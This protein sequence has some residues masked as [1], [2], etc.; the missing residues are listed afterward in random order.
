MWLQ[1]AEPQTFDPLHPNPTYLLKSYKFVLV[2]GV[3]ATL[4]SAATDYKSSNQGFYFCGWTVRPHTFNKAQTVQ[5]QHKSP[6]FLKKSVSWNNSNLFVLPCR[7]C[8]FIDE[9]QYVSSGSFLP[10][11]SQQTD[12]PRSQADTLKHSRRHHLKNSPKSIISSL[13]FSTDTNVIMI[14]FN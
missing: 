6:F 9:E 2:A 4:R 5:V 8:L 12:P 10:A 7:I 14:G 1:R 13:K 3:I 11:L